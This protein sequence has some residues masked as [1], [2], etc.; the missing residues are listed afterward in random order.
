MILKA[1]K[2][3]RYFAPSKKVH[4]IDSF[5]V[6]LTFMIKWVLEFFGI[7]QKYRQYTFSKPLFIPFS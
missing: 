2:N 1:Q 7:Y 5:S 4:S 6:K 3:D